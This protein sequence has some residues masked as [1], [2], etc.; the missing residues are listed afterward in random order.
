MVTWC[1]NDKKVYQIMHIHYQ[2]L[3]ALEIISM[4]HTNL[5]LSYLI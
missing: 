4:N 2:Y 1:T 5:F 3:L